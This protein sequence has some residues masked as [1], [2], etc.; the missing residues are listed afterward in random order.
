MNLSIAFGFAQSPDQNYVKSIELLEAIDINTL[1]TNSNA[2]KK[3]ESVTY[4]DGFGRAKQIQK[5]SSP[6][7]Y[8]PCY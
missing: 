5:P 2:V 1:N 7:L 6:G 4:F 8:C 3:I